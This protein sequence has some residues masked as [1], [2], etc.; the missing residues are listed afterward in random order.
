M[1]NTYRWLTSSTT[2]DI[3]ND[4]GT[5]NRSGFAGLPGG[6]GNSN[7]LFNSIGNN[8]YWW[9]STVS[10]AITWYQNLFYNFGNVFRNN[11]NKRFGFSIRCVRD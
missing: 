10:G 11:F 6:G 4:Q 2:A 1:A 8:G 3:G 5:N 9:S 7:G